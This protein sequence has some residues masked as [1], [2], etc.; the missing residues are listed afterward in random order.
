MNSIHLLK[1]DKVALR[2][3]HVVKNKFK[4][5]FD[6]YAQRLSQASVLIADA[7][8]NELNKER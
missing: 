7:L 3:Y 8:I 2:K 5:E 1:N 4:D 6:E